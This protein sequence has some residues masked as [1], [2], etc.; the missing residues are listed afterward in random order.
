MFVVAPS[1]WYE[2]NPMSIIEAFAYGKPV[3]GARIGGIP[4]LVE[5]G[6]TGLLFSTG[7]AMGLRR[8]IEQIL[9]NP[10]LISEYGRNAR[11]RAEERFSRARYAEGLFA[12]YHEAIEK[13]ETP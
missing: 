13:H 10:G 3:I 8:C 5:D 11:A 1:E 12:I 7:D 9:A 4:E 2:N 6:E